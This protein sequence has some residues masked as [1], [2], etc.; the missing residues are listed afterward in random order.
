MQFFRLAHVPPQPGERVFAYSRCRAVLAAALLAGL[1]FG[2]IFYAWARGAW[3]G[4][5]IGG[6]LLLCLMIFHKLITARFRSSNWLVRA[7]NDGLF[8][9]FRSY[10]NAHF[11]DRDLTVVFF[12]YSEITA[13]TLVRLVRELADREGSHE[14]RGTRS[15]RRAVELEVAI[16]CIEL[17]KLLAN[18]RERIFGKSVVGA[19]KISTRY[20]HMPVRLTALRRLR[21]DWG[22]VPDPQSLIE[23]LARHSIAWETAVDETD[24]TRLEKLPKAEQEARLLELIEGG[25][26]LGA[27]ALTRRLY[28]FDLARAKEFVEE[29]ATQK[30]VSERQPAGNS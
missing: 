29:L 21:V 25:D 9:K 18:E 22:V 8:V 2:A 17:S 23:I 24:F 19:G 12:P 5:Y 14:S 7:T 11:D 1:A 15:T 28:A 27:V 30:P 26:K 6:V 13:A 3:L 10:L 4:Y 16:D 20:Q